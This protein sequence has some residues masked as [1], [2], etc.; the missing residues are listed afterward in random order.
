MININIKKDK[1]DDDRFLVVYIFPFIKLEVEVE[2][3][4]S[5]NYLWSYKFYACLV[6]WNFNNTI[7]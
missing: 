4:P 7:K 1:R 3:E 6:F 5:A 2:L